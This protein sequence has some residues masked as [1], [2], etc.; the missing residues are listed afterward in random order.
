MANETR[1][2]G[3]AEFDWDALAL[4]GYSSA[5]R[6]E[7]SD[8]YEGTLNSV[9]EREVIE[10]TIVSLNKKEVV[11]NIGSKSEGVIPTSEF[12]YNPDLKVG[13]V[14]PVYVE[15]QEDKYGQ[16]VLSHRIA[17]VHSAWIKV[18]KY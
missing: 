10:G 9:A 1:T 2:Q 7:Y 14:V 3:T 16:L 8:K 17:R 13:D 18:R 12:R 15:T 5:Q 4:D 11:I 6:A